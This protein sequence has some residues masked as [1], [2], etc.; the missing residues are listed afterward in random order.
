MDPGALNDAR[1]ALFR[2]MTRWEEQRVAVAPLTPTLKTL[3]LTRKCG[4]DGD[5]A[6]PPLKVKVGARAVVSRV[7]DDGDDLALGHTVASADF[8][9]AVVHVDGQLVPGVLHDHVCVRRRL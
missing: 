7:A 4:V 5:A 8:E 9:P 3:K 2:K 1:L 6:F